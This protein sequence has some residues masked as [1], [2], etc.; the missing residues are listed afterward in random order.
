MRGES[1]LN[2]DV[3]VNHLN[4]TVSHAHADPLGSI[5]VAGIRSVRR[6]FLPLPQVPT[7]ISFVP[8]GIVKGGG[9]LVVLQGNNVA[10]RDVTGE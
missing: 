5:S 4:I 7:I 2:E 1:H 8:V 6:S 10:S 3:R 9:I